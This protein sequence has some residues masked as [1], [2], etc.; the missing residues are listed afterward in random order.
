MWLVQQGIECFYLFIL[1]NLNLSLSNHMWLV[2]IL[3]NSTGLELG[4]F[5]EQT[6]LDKRS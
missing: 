6:S 2:A 4:M 1:I 3:L 5:L